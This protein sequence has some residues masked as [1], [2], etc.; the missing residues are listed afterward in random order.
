MRRKSRSNIYD[1]MFWVLFMN[2][3]K[4]INKSML[5]GDDSLR[6]GKY[7]FLMNSAI[8]CGAVQTDRCGEVVPGSLFSMN[9]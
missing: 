7:W 3:N 1:F 4:E 8:K 5:H 2:W 6:Q 9:N